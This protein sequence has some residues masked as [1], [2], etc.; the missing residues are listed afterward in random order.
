MSAGTSDF[1]HPGKDYV[2]HISRDL[3][4]Q[5]MSTQNDNQNSDR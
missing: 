2:N 4:T 1:N 5:I 3:S